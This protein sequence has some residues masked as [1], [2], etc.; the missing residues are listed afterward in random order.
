MVPKRVPGGS[1]RLKLAP[2]SPRNPK[3]APSRPQAAGN[4]PQERSMCPHLEDAHHG[5]IIS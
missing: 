5:V 1:R 4:R 3:W 2:G